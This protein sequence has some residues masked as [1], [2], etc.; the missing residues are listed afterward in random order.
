M[1]VMFSFGKSY[2]RANFVGLLVVFA[3]MILVGLF[4]ATGFSKSIF[5]PPYIAFILQLFFVLGIGLAV[6]FVSAKS[7]IQTGAPNIL[8]LGNAILISSLSFTVSATVLTL[9][10]PPTLTANQAVIIGNVGVLISSLVLLVSAIV[11]WLGTEHNPAF[12]KKTMLAIS[13]VISIATV[14]IISISSALDLFPVF[15][16]NSG[17]TLLRLVILGLTTIFYFASSALFGGKY[18]RVRSQVVFWFALA[19]ALFGTAYLAGVL[20]VHVGSAMTWVSRLGLYL[21]GVYLLFALLGPEGKAQKQPSV[22]KWSEAF[23]SNPKQAAD[24]F[25]R[26]LNAFA[27]FKILINKGGKPIDYVILDI[28]EAFEKLT[29]LNK[30]YVLG[31]KASE[32]MNRDALE[33]WLSILGPVAL[34]GEAVTLDHFSKFSKKWVHMTVYSPQKSYLVSISE[35]ITER[36]KA[37]EAIT[38]QALL[39]SRAREA[40]FGIDAK[41]TITY[42]NKGA[43]DV[44]GWSKEE[45]IG[46][47]SGELLQTKIDGSSRTEQVNKLLSVGQWHGEA[48]YLKK[49][50]SFILVEVS[51]AT[52]MGP[53]GE[54]Q[55][56]VTAARDITER[57]LAESKIQEYQNNLEK[58]VE[59]RTK[60]LKDSERLAAI[61]ATAGMVGHDIRNPLQ[62]IT[63]D[64]YLAKT[65]LALTPETE[66]KKNAIESLIEIE[67]NIDYINKI[68]Q[69]LQDYARPLQP[70]AKG[71]DLENLCQEVFLKSHIPNNIKT[72]CKTEKEAKQVFA[73]P[74]LLKRVISNLVLNAVQAMP[75]GGKLSLYAYRNEGG[76]VIEVQDTGEGIS[77]EAKPK[78]FTPMFTTKSKGQG[79]GLAVVKRVTESMGGTVT[80]KSEKGKG[81]T[82]TVRLPPPKEL[83]GK[84]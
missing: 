20:T 52:L 84:I 64:V 83:S 66:E 41:Y 61:G 53:N 51:A 9:Q 57:K 27:Y 68:V 70:T 81:T 24:F 19:L 71:T 25:S 73:D 47:N 44:F 63:S 7:Y 46:K 23:R 65:E 72:S 42:W 79:F 31:K 60:Q 3:F 36:K 11:T 14:T 78:L 34:T 28:N 58:L 10:I 55:G 39:L 30:N 16:T 74:D 33:D 8:L 21:S 75:K 26:M 77:D 76:L 45:A 50:S 5:N 15:L 35:D 6:A 17:P 29:G 56:I 1:G 67:K 4:F 32:I 69:D 62:A 54:L 43:E 49:D 38:Y 59:E 48:Q 12:P 2:N 22:A 37:E 80:F 82:F 18:V 40:I 13:F